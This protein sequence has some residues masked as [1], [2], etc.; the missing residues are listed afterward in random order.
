MLDTSKL[1][2]EVDDMLAKKRFQEKIA[3]KS[4]DKED[5]I[6]TTAGGVG[7]TSTRDQS[8]LVSNRS[9]SSRPIT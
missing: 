5:K 2:E 9:Q 3:E 1:N 6:E 8:Q 7:A 4:A